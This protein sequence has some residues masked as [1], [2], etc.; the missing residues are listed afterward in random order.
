V[1]VLSK[2]AI[3]SLAKARPVKFCF[4]WFSFLSCFLC[5]FSLDE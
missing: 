5:C 2:I 1:R 4:E 3:I